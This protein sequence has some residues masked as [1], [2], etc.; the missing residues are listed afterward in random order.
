M[1]GAVAAGAAGLALNRRARRLTVL[2]EVDRSAEALD[3]TG[4]FTLV[5][6]AGVSVDAGTEAAA[7]GHALV[8]DLDVVD[9]VPGDLP[10][11]VLQ[12][13]LLQIDPGRY[14]RDRLAVGRGAGHAGVVRTA[15][16]ARVAA[17]HPSP[18]DGWRGSTRWRTSSCRA[19]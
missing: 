9:L 19:G 13:L 7:V 12:A 16:L 2:S 14:R 6:A 8:H 11:G 1:V 5:T 10:S 17:A 4:S 15:L 18:S 3:P